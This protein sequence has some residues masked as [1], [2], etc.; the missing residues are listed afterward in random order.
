MC[1]PTV[2]TL[3]ALP[4]HPK[5]MVSVSPS[6][7]IVLRWGGRA[8]QTATDSAAHKRGHCRADAAAGQAP[9]CHL[10]AVGAAGEPPAGHWEGVLADG[11]DGEPQEAA[12]AA[13]GVLR[14]SRRRA[15]SG[16]VR[17]WCHAVKLFQT[18]T[19]YAS[20]GNGGAERTGTFHLAAAEYA[21]NDGA[22]ASTKQDAL[23]LYPSLVHS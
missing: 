12:A 1:A 7:G 4:T 6:A 5:C 18:T 17:W 13:G 14:W 22:K 19:A 21:V 20:Q 10:G 3:P 2:L 16:A 11:R 8:V 23:V 15:L 9:G